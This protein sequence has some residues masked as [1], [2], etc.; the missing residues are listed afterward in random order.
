MVCSGNEKGFF[1]SLR[2]LIIKRLICLL[3][4]SKEFA[5][6]I[7]ASFFFIH[8]VFLSFKRMVHSSVEWPSFPSILQ[9]FSFL[10]RLVFRYFISANLDGDSIPA[11]LS[12]DFKNSSMILILLAELNKAVRFQKMIRRLHDRTEQTETCSHYRINS[13]HH[14]SLGKITIVSGMESN[15]NL[16]AVSVIL[17]SSK[18]VLK[19]RAM[20]TLAQSKLFV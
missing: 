3:R 20:I 7:D 15:I 16:G 4:P 10:N 6:L 9:Y 1:N 17:S 11:T 13:L 18:F 8:P 5:I 2:Q 12:I 14:P 19:F